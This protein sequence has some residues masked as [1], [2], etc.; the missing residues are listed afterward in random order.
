MPEA[1]AGLIP[2][3]NQMGWMTV[4]LDAF[5]QAFVD[6]APTAPGPVLDIGAAYGV[7][8]IAALN[9][10]A[11]VIANDLDPRHLEI[12]RDNAPSA[13][14]RNLS[15]RPGAFPDELDFE[16]DSLGG[17]LA[18]RILHFFDGPTF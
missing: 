6:F 12:L 10:G 9:K 18:C 13:Y 8:S 1:K 3:L 2:T 15:L 4:G 16:E 5:S 14:A 17:I 7:A 11:R